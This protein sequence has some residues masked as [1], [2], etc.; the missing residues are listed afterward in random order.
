VADGI[1]AGSRAD[2]ARKH[3]AGAWHTAG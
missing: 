2:G 1:R 3:P